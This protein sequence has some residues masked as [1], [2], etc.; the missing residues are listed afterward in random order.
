LQSAGKDKLKNISKSWPLLHSAILATELIAKATNI[1]IC[2][3]TANLHEDANYVLYCS[4]L[5]SSQL[6]A[7]LSDN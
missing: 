5:K 2:L 7:T 6:F 3:L 4:S 1:L